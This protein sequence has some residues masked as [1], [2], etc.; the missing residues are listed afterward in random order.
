MKTLIL[1]LALL[2]PAAP[3]MAIN[4]VWPAWEA[5]KQNLITRDGRVVDP[6]SASRMTTSEG[7]SYGM[8]FALTANDPIVFRRILRWTEDNL[9]GG[10]MTSRLPAWSWG[11]TGRG[12]WRILDQNSASDADLWI[13]YSL[14]E[15]G[16]LWNEHSHTLLGTLLAQRIAREEV[17]QLPGLGAM[18]LPGKSGF[19]DHGAW[20]LN[21]S[22]LPLQV[23]TRLSLEPGPWG[24]IKDTALKLLTE[25]APKG[26]APDW[27]SWLA[28]QG[29]RVDPLHGDTGSY[30]AIRVYL[31]IGMLHDTNRE[32]AMLL[33][34][35]APMSDSVAKNGEPPEKIDTLT[36]QAYGAGPSGFSAALLPFLAGTPAL[37]TQRDRLE[38]QPPEPRAY[39]DQVLT[40]FGFGWDQGR[41]GFDEEGQLMT[42]WST[43]TH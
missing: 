8:F 12:D 25:T 9:A 35:F 29:W 36:G 43:C 23:L 3:S 37:A 33:A 2:L 1:T 5:F 11:K 40:L 20:R 42:T 16:R 21:P 30:N 38:R 41:F 15:A 19:T 24:E 14:L 27:V 7:Q 31:W 28:P 17:A 39:Y 22:Y 26:Y 13:A 18:L 4:C 6:S 10:D 32:K 34:H